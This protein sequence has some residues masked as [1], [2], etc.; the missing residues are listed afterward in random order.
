MKNRNLLVAVAAFALAFAVP[1]ADLFAK[2]GGGGGG[3]SFSSGS[4]RS[5]SSPSPSKSF[6]SP[7]PSPSRSYS[8]PTPSAPKFSSPA[9][10]VQAP[11]A[12]AP[13]FSS[14]STPAPSA[15]VARAPV[16]PKSDVGKGAAQAQQRQE[17]RKAF[18]AAN[19][20]AKTATPTQVAQATPR[21]NADKQR[22]KDLKKDLSY[23]RMQNRQLRE[24]QAYGGYYG[25]QGPCC[26]NDGFNMFFWLWLLDRPQHERDTWAYHHRDQI[27]PQRMNELRANDADFE[28][29]LK[30]LEQSGVKKDSSYVPANVDRDLMYSKEMAEEAYK[31]NNTSSF[32]WFWVIGFITLGGVAYL[33]FFK[34]FR[35]RKG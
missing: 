4:S 18:E 27:D 23:E 1:S 9:P 17:S 19:P 11:S 14:P 33:V 5:F 31:E 2:G 25:R 15:P 20:P 10:Q 21:T 6:S 12:P 32:P 3:R 13:K 34:R 30:K 24:Q 8:T 29:R 35:V 26:Y 7:K 22:V 28:N 16:A